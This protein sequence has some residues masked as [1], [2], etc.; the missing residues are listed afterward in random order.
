[1]ASSIELF[2][3]LAENSHTPRFIENRQG[4]YD[5]ILTMVDDALNVTNEAERDESM[6]KYLHISD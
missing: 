6:K 3:I 4:V 5:A 2:N 1:M